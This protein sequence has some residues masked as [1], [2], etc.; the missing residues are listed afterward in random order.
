MNAKAS[1][2]AQPLDH[3]VATAYRRP[4]R[5]RFLN[6]RRAVL[7]AAVLAVL[8]LTT[9][10]ADQAADAER[11]AIV[12]K[13]C[14]SCHVVGPGAKNRVGPHLNGIFGRRAATIDGFNYSDDIVRAGVN[15]LFWTAEKLDIYM[16][17]PQTLV[18]GTRM[19]Y[20]GLKDA[21]D[22]RDVIAFLRQYSDNPRDI[23]EAA[24]TAVSDPV[25]PS[26][27][28]TMQGDMAFGEYLSGECVTCHRIDGTDNGISSITGWPTEVFITALHAYRSKARDHPVM[29]MIAAPLANEEIAALAAYFATKGQ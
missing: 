3:A 28:L 11:G 29:R 12:F 24:P 8:P 18:S 10:N 9:V 21:G 15:G 26:E 13:A 17:D 4:G 25:L 7:A 19:K 22:R 2:H 20:R 27:I 6:P 14:S 5:V 1:K 16:E 23:P